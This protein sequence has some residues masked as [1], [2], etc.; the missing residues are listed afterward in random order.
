MV[1]LCSSFKK[2]DPDNTIILI[3]KK[4]RPIEPPL[5]AM[6]SSQPLPKD[7]TM[8]VNVSAWSYFI[9]WVVG[10]VQIEV[11]NLSSQLYLL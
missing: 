10:S 3:L 5:K 8:L 4:L 7:M 9:L 1:L 2:E 6:Y 11:W